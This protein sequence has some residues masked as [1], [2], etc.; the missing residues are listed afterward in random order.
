MFA[1]RIFPIAFALAL[2]T[3]AVAQGAPVSTPAPDAGA[4]STMPRD[5][6]KPMARHDHGAEKGTPTP[7][8]A[9]CPTATTASPAKAK[10]KPGHDH[11]RF[12][13]LM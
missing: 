10:S 2:S 12:H 4:A 5:C 11:A 9:V 13:K 8:S 7:M 6:T 1:S 3:A